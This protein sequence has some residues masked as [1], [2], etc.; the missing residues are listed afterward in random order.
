MRRIY[1]IFLLLFVMILITFIGVLKIDNFKRLDNKIDIVPSQP[2]HV[3]HTPTLETHDLIPKTDSEIIHEV[4]DL[5]S[6]W[7]ASLNKPG[8]FYTVEKVE[9]SPSDY[10][11]LEDGTKIPVDYQ[12]DNWYLLNGEGLVLASISTMTDVNGVEVQRVIFTGT[13]WYN[14][15][16]DEKYSGSPYVLKLDYGLFET[17]SKGSDFYGDLSV[18]EGSLDGREII[19]KGKWSILG[20]VRFS[21]WTTCWKLFQ[22]LR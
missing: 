6:S 1:P 13:A 2:V 7:V 12:M 3:N 14:L 17:L 22:E 16:V 20:D 21:N 19:R 4:N 15:A 8:W 11:T 5:H 18:T 9:R 10:G